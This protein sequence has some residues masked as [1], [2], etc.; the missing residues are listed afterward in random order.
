MSLELKRKQHELAA[1][2]LAKQGM[3]LKIEE[4]KEE[5]KRLQEHI[6]VQDSAVEKLMI[7]IERIKG[8]SNG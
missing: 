1:V 6:L 4:R 7:E 5:I 8:D 2:M 3:E